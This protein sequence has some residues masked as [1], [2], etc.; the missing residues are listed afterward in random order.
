MQQ[1]YTVPEVAARIEAVLGEAPNSYALYRA[2][3]GRPPRAGRRSLVAG[4]PAP[5]NIDGAR[6]WSAP[7]IETWLRNHP[8]LQLNAA[9]AEFETNF[10]AA[11]HQREA[12]AQAVNQAKEQGCSWAEIAEVISHVEQTRITRQGV[13]KRYGTPAPHPSRT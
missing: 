13:A 10:R 2:G 1:R 9:R 6:T 3:E 5:H 8:I 4:M 12:Q 7:E 11:A